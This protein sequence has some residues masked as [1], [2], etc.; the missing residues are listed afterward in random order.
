M[1][2]FRCFW[3]FS[4]FQISGWFSFCSSANCYWVPPFHTM[5]QH[6]GPGRHPARWPSSQK[7]NDVPCMLLFGSWVPHPTCT[8]QSTWWDISEAAIETSFVSV[9]EGLHDSIDGG[10]AHFVD[11]MWNTEWEK[12]KTRIPDF[13]P[14][15][16]VIAAGIY[17]QIKACVRLK[18]LHAC[19]GQFG[20]AVSEPPIRRRRSGDE[21]F[22]RRDVSAMVVA[23]VLCE[24][25]VC[26]WNTLEVRLQ[27]MF[28]S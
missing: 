25:Y 15:I 8:H 2:T 6:T 20:A 9:A 28:A 21:P 16:C 24:K 14:C 3:H 17:L 7:C 22:R 13:F 19:L 1:I 4:D 10:A 12:S 27:R 18:P 11:Q 23:N 26:C 5:E